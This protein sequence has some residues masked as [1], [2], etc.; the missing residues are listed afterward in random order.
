MIDDGP[1]EPMNGAFD[2]NQ[3]TLVFHPLRPKLKTIEPDN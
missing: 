1:E 2:L 3:I